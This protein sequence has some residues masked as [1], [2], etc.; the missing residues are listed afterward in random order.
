MVSTYR[1]RKEI[2]EL[3]NQRQV[4]LAMAAHHVLS[5]NPGM[6]EEELSESF[7][8]IRFH[9]WLTRSLSA[10][11][12]A[13]SP[14]ERTFLGS[15]VTYAIY[16]QAFQ[17]EFRVGSDDVETDIARVSQL[18]KLRSDLEARFEARSR[19]FDEDAAHFPAEHL[20]ELKTEHVF[21]ETL[22]DYLE[23]LVVKGELKQR[24]RTDAFEAFPFFVFEHHV[25]CFV[26]PSVI[27]G[28]KQF[29]PDLLLWQPN[30]P[31]VKIVVECDGYDY[32]SS[33]DMFTKDRQRDR[34]LYA[35]GYHVLRY[36]GSEIFDDPRNVIRDVHMHMMLDSLKAS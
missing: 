33:P 4:I 34:A 25:F 16:Q 35:N 28:S 22:E 23:T 13:E 26:Q 12:L 18:I 24:D 19:D 11:E 15:M 14:I 27:C 36:S 29:R 8:V 32:H 21:C 9:N 7:E 1:E 17:V 10:I 30:K 31:D 6:S 2:S 20:H 5:E 3:L